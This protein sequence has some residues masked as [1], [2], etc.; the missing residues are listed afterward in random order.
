[1]TENTMNQWCQEEADNNKVTNLNGLAPTIELERHLGMQIYNALQGPVVEEV[2]RKTKIYSGDTYWRSNMEGHSLNVQKELLPDFYALCHEV[3]EKLNFTDAVE[4]YVTGDSTVNAFSLAAESKDEPHIVNVNSALF[5]LMSTDELR[6]VIGHELGHLINKDTALDRLIGFVFPPQVNMPVLLHY[7]VHLH[8]Q[9]AELVA[10]RYGFIA[11]ENFDACVT[12][13][14][15]MAS[16]LD[17]NKMNVS[18]DA[19]IA[20]NNRRLEYF[21]HDK[22]ISRA[23]HPVNPIRVQALNLYA[24]AQSEAELQTGMEDLIAILLKIG[25]G[26][27]DEHMARFIASAGLIVMNAD[28]EVANEEV[29]DVIGALAGVKIFPRQFLD[30]MA[31]GDV[32]KIFNDAVG[33]ILNINPGMREALLDYVIHISLSDK[34]IAADEVSLIYQFG[35]SIGLSEIEVANAIASAIQ[36]NYVP[37]I[38]AI[39]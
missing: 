20:D 23:T 39:W 27:I 30:E 29:N 12:A 6:F 8:R 3:K 14:F 22:G 4:F 13:F 26:E 2:L 5:D 11:T 33:N 25:D 16:G 34:I 37:S 1:M 24:H 19:L 35:D 38:E 10:D 21:M 17:L 32:V 9:L 15:K 18:I 28:G 31:K 36:Q 7:K